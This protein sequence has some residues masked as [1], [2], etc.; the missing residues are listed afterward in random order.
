MLPEIVAESQASS[1]ASSLIIY[2]QDAL[3]DEITSLPGL[4]DAIT[5]RQFSGYIDVSDS[6]KM[7]YW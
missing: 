1:P 7:F 6:K 4:N 2:S 5:F 3:K